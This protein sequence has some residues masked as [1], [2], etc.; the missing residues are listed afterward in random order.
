MLPT[1]RQDKREWPGVTTTGLD[2]RAQRIWDVDLGDVLAT[3]LIEADN[4]GAVWGVLGQVEARNEGRKARRL[5][6]SILKRRRR[7]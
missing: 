3:V 2:R 1:Y 4:V 5:R 7:C 6:R